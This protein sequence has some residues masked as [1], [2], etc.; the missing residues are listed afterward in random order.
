VA[1][2]LLV[3][4]VVGLLDSGGELG[5]LRLVLGAD[6]GDGEDGSGLLVNDGSE[7][8]L[9]LD[10]AVGNTH[11]AAKSGKEDNQ[12][13]GVNIVG[14]EDQGSLLVLDQT[15]NVVKTVLDSVG[16]LGHILLLLSLLDGLSLLDETRLLLGLGLR[17]VLVEDT[18]DLGGQVLVGG[19]LELSDR[20]R[21]LQ[22]HV[23]DLLLA[24][25]TDILGPLDETG[26]V[27]LGLDV[28]TDTEVTGTLLE[29]RVLL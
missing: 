16:L 27:A 25:K 14:D 22:A 5:E 19:V 10:D 18:E 26:E 21:N 7:T 2:V 1:A 12:L 4:L 23:E 29:E 15:N 11:L 17:A 8:G 3:L 6:L 28:L 9:A 20:R 13:N 24:L